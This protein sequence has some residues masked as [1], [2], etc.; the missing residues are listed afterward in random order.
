MRERYVHLLPPLCTFTQLTPPFFSL[1]HN[2]SNGYYSPITY[3]LAKL[4]FDIIPLRV[5]PPFILG[6]I[7]YG[8]AGL[9]AEV[10]AFWK[11]IMILVLFNLTASSIV[12]FLSVAISDL[13]VANLLGSLVMLY[14]Y[15]LKLPSPPLFLT[16]LGYSFFAD[17]IPCSFS[18]LFAGLL[19][20]YD[21]VPDGLKWMLTTSFF[22][23]GYEA[24][25]VNELRYLQLVERKFGLD[26][27]VPSATSKFYHPPP[28]IPASF[29]FSLQ[30][31][32][33]GSVFN[34]PLII[35]FPRASILVA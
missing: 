19:M 10:S 8:L 9:N 29:F 30:K 24:L 17:F 23:A 34:S 14:K 22:H 35:R 32:I 20:N 6:S 13:G 7:V 1:G 2:R 16:I 26:I 4:L 5:I 28:P 25:L 12:L 18:L 27:Q 21:R 31:L 3:F 15:V 11:F 33:C